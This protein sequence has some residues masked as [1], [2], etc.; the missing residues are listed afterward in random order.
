MNI[1]M[2]IVIKWWHYGDCDNFD[3]IGDKFHYNGQHFEICDYDENSDCCDE[4]IDNYDNFWEVIMKRA[5]L[6]IFDYW[7]LI[8]QKAK[9]TCRHFS[10]WIFSQSISDLQDHKTQQWKTL[11][12][13]NVSCVYCL[14]N[15]NKQQF[16]K[17]P[18][19]VTSNVTFQLGLIILRTNSIFCNLTRKGC[20]ML[21]LLL[22]PPKNQH[23]SGLVWIK[24][25][26]RYILILNQF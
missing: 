21:H 12:S 13:Q 2:K 24:F 3:D 10:K 18:R 19:V 6:M 15:K 25:N 8:V 26:Q 20:D 14:W 4:N 9:I 5:W 22:P 7:P 17:S 16:T 11:C 23:G 1:M